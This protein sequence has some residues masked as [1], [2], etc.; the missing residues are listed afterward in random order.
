MTMLEAGRLMRMYCI[1]K[2]IQKMKLM[3]PVAFDSSVTNDISLSSLMIGLAH[4]S[5]IE[6]GR[7]LSSVKNIIQKSAR[8]SLLALFRRRHSFIRIISRMMAKHGADIQ[9]AFIEPVILSKENICCG[10][11]F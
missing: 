10:V 2:L 7:Q 1:E 3:A 5:S 9:K 8:S 4:R 6:K 11:F